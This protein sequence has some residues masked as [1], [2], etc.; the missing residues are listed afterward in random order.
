[1]FP[2]KTK[3]HSGSRGRQGRG[4]VLSQVLLEVYGTVSYD[5]TLLSKMDTDITFN[6]LVILCVGGVPRLHVDIRGQLAVLF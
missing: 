6:Y 4:C 5:L 2:I 3:K 1:M